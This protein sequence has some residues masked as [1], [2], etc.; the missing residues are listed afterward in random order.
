MA[1]IYVN[2]STESPNKIYC[3]KHQQRFWQGSGIILLVGS[4]LG[5]ERHLQS[6]K[7][8][9]GTIYIYERDISTYH[10]LKK[11]YLQLKNKYPNVLIRNTDALQHDLY[12]EP[13]DNID[14]DSCDS[15]LKILT[16]SF[17]KL[18]SF[19][20]K[21]VKTIS[22]TFASRNPNKEYLNSMQKLLI[23]DSDNFQASQRE[24]YSEYINKNYPNYSCVFLYSYRGVS[25]VPMFCVTAVKR[26]FII[27]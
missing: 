19:F 21:E 12:K 1:R 17:F 18:H 14:F 4:P 16:P 24:F 3:E 5:L 10:S 8:I 26:P 25:G 9:S 11:S 7:N 2:Y 20:L 23:P 22:V 6:C 15:M 13:V 27:N